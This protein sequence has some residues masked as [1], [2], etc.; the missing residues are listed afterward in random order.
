MSD[1][2]RLNVGRCIE[3][4]ALDEAGARS[5]CVEFFGMPPEK[6]ERVLDAGPAGRP[7]KYKP[8]ARTFQVFLVGASPKPLRFRSRR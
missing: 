2:H 6:I 3:V 5:F 4:V 1:V 8:E 7:E